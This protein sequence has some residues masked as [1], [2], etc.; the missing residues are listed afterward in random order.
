MSP[1]KALISMAGFFLALTAC[2]TTGRAQETQSSQPSV[3]E[4]ARRAREQQKNQPKATKVFTDDDISNLKGTIS[5]VGTLPAPPPKT[6]SQATTTTQAK[7]P[8]KDEAYWRKRF[9]DA[10]RALA[11]DSRELDVLQREYNLKQIQFYSNPNVALR[12]QYSRK[13]L[14]DTL[15]Q[16]NAKKQDVDKDNQALNDLQDELR[17]SGGEPGWA[18]EDSQP[19]SQ[20]ESQSSQ[21]DQTGQQASPSQTAPEQSSQP[22]QAAP[23]GEQPESQSPSESPSQP[24]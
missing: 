24:Q 10:R 2:L 18:N 22:E 5:V 6:T 12:E 14:D 13:D 23:S 3:A 8:V 20:T 16:I 17:K 21:S 7:G 1:H 15:A 19:N 4:A 11:D 9:A